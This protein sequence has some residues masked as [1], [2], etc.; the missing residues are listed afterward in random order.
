MGLGG[1][2]TAWDPFLSAFLNIQSNDFFSGE[3][4]MLLGHF[5]FNDLKILIEQNALD[6]DEK[7]DA[8]RHAV[9]TIDD[10]TF[11]LSPATAITSPTRVT[12]RRTFVYVRI[13]CLE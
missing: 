6:A 13:S 7:A 9:V 11:V 5:N 1:A 8:Y 10:D 2:D 4:V 3:D 12:K